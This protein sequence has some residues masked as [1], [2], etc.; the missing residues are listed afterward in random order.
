MQKALG[1]GA[2]VSEILA[3]FETPEELYLAGSDEIGRAHV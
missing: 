1:A 2:N 3:Y